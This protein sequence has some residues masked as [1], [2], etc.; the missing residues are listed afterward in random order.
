MAR[1]LTTATVLAIVTTLVLRT[2]DGDW[3]VAWVA[4]LGVLAIRLGLMV[5]EVARGALPWTRL[6]LPSLIWVEGVGLAGEGMWEVRAATALAL[7]LALI[8]VAI[9]ALKHRDVIDVPVEVR[10]ARGLETIVPP[11]I[12]RLAAIEMTIVGLAVRFLAGGWRKPVPA[13]LTYHRENGM[14]QML[15]IM[16][17]LAIG[18]VLFL[19]LVVLPNAVAWLRVVVHVVAAYGVIWLIGLY[20]STRARPHRLVDDRL[21]LYRGALGHITIARSE[22]ARIAPMPTFGDAWKQRAYKRASVRLDLGAAHVLELTLHDR[23]RLLV[24]VDDPETFKAAL[25]RPPGCPI[26]IP[27]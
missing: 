17:L 12:A 22:I 9:R 18:D 23:R 16:P 14:R 8:G 25:Q 20:A 27:S 10:I 7:E 5:R 19:E 3:Q 2:L 21:E 26:A 13:G 4:A 11:R 15:P 1:W 6:L 24:G